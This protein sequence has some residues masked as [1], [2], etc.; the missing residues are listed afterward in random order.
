MTR[1]VCHLTRSVCH[2]T[3]LLTFSLG[4]VASAGDNWP[5]FRGPAMDGH[6]DA[7][8]LP[9]EWGEGKNVRWKTAIAGRGWSTP[10][11]W[12][13][14]IWLTT[15]TSDGKELYALCLN[16]EDG[17]VT[18]RIK[19]F[20]VEKPETIHELNSHASPSPVIEA[21]RV[22]LHFGTHG[23]AAIN[24]ETG[25]IL[26]KRADLNVSHSVGPGSSPVLS[27][28]LLILTFDGTDS[29]YITALDTADGETRWRTSRS[30]DLSSVQPES[31][32]SFSTPVIA[33]VDGKQQIITTG[34]QSAYGYDAESGKELWRLGYEGFSHASRP[35]VGN[36]MMFLNTGYMKA[37]VLGVKLGGRG[38]VT[39]THVA[40]QQ[41]SGAPN[42]PSPLLIGDLFY[43]ISDGGVASC[44]D[45]KTG[46]IVWTKRFGGSFSSSPIHAAGRIYSSDQDGK[47]FVFQPGRE[48]QQLA[49]NKLDE[50][51]MASPAVSGKAI[52]LRTKTCLYRIEEGA[53]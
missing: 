40:W 41:A 31:R 35:V 51:C 53:K 44:L 13:E 39:D 42:K 14:Q 46:E 7:Q 10:V 38:N 43:M 23:T 47:T 20:E 22:Y 11:I 49:V 48:F 15:A 27:G 26:W 4:S 33:Q 24:T 9:L 8:E 30:V 3:L 12:G 52:Y 1:S 29:Q 21:G 6:S 36:G 34:A 37:Q 50:G 17:Q 32:K 16:K 19:V 28:K 25:I 18:Q 5:E 45:S 2:L